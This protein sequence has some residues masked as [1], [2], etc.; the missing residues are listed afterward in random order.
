MPSSYE[1]TN[2]L[3][4]ETKKKK[5]HAPKTRIGV[6]T[7]EMVPITFHTD[8]SHVCRLKYESTVSKWQMLM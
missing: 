3:D 6:A 2:Q 4:S 1:L 7:T 8:T 5:K